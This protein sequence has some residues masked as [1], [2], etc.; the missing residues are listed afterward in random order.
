MDKKEFITKHFTKIT[1]LTA[2]IFFIVAMSIFA[3]TKVPI[4]KKVISYTIVKH[5]IIAPQPK[6]TGHLVQTAQ[7]IPVSSPTSTTLQ[8]QSQQA[9]IP[10]PT[11]ISDPTQTQQSI[12]HMQISEPDGT[13]NFSIPAEGNACDELTEA[14]DE[15]KIHSVTF[16]SS[17][18]NSM[19]S[20]YIKEI[21]G[22]Q[23]NWTFTINGQGPAGC[24]LASPKSGDTVIWK[25][26]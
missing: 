21:N 19:H 16:N 13:S 5:L 1:F 22:Y 10:T 26:S 20:L 4:S 9:A 8:S 7:P 25:F 12:V 2:A 6:T 11:P 15:D 23:N 14:K 17:Y 18:M 3:F 24:S